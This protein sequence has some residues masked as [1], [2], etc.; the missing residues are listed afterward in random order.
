MGLDPGEQPRQD[1]LQFV[2]SDQIAKEQGG[3]RQTTPVKPCEVQ[4]LYCHV[5]LRLAVCQFGI[6]ERKLSLKLPV[7]AQGQATQMESLNDL[8]AS[9]FAPTQS[10][11]DPPSP[12]K[13]YPIG[14]PDSPLYVRADMTCATQLILESPAPGYHRGGQQG[15]INEFLGK[16]LAIHLLRTRTFKATTSWS[17]SIYDDARRE[18][19]ADPVATEKMGI[20]VFAYLLAKVDGKV[21]IYEIK[22]GKLGGA[23]TDAQYKNRKYIAANQ[24]T[25]GDAGAMPL[26]PGVSQ[27]H[28]LIDG[29]SDGFFGLKEIY[30]DGDRIFP[31]E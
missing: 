29:T 18:L 7:L 3:T 24:F 6:G 31:E 9:G 16:A 13:L 28:V 15:A 27:V 25:D 8:T 5:G 10:S 23:V 2:A 30:C 21:D 12:K 22:D 4:K 19:Q 14:N 17:S 20:K 1:A 26:I 11:D